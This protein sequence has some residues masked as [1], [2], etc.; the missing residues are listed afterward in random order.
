MIADESTKRNSVGT[1]SRSFLY[2][3]RR[4]CPDGAHFNGVYAALDALGGWLL[5]ALCPQLALEG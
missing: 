3:R 2:W 1:G 4:S 5:G